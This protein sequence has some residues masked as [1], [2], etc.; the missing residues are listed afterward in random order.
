M[1]GLQRWAETPESQFQDDNKAKRDHGP[2][3]RGDRDGQWID[4][5]KR[6]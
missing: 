3:K 6:E 1:E 5:V 2:G 4:C